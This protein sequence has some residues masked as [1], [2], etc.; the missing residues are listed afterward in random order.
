MGDNSNNEVGGRVSNKR[1]NRKY[2]GGIP[3]KKQEP[4]E[5]IILPQCVKNY[6]KLAVKLILKGH[7]ADG[8]D[9]IIERDNNNLYRQVQEWIA[10]DENKRLLLKISP[11]NIKVTVNT[12]PQERISPLPNRKSN[13]PLN[14][15][16]DPIPDSLPV[17]TP[18]PAQQY[19]GIRSLSKKQNVLRQGV[20]VVPLTRNRRS[21]K[22]S[23][24]KSRKSKKT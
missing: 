18:P 12:L 19:P 17:S 14:I 15:I 9:E 4:M 6:K 1:N 11:S 3:I 7:D 24:K 8:T 10:D 2:P 5:N 22:G 23:S 13:Q 20:S 16:L 21:R